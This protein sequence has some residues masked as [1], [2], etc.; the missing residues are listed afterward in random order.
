MRLGMV[1]TDLDGTLL[2]SQHALSVNDRRALVELGERGVVRVIATGRSLFSAKRV[3]PADLPIDYLVHTSGAGIMRWPEQRSLRALA[4]RADLA[5]DLAAFLVSQ[6]CDFMLHHAIPNNHC[7]YAHR[8]S[9]HNPDFEH[10]VQA[11]AEFA[12]ELAWPRTLAAM[13]CQVVIIEPPGPSRHEELRAA[14]P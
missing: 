4:M 6:R 7:F 1:V 2:N 9:A 8:A 5:H 12:S 3:L 11:Y 10:R 14:L 13:M